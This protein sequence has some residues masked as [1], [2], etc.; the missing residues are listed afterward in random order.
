MMQSVPIRKI[1]IARTTM[2][3][4]CLSASL[5][6]HTIRL[7]PFPSHAFASPTRL[8]QFNCHPKCGHRGN[9]LKRAEEYC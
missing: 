4:G 1:R 3:W 5:T 9:L 7:S 2:V 6:I 8:V